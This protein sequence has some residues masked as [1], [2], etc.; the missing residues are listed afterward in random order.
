M[1]WLRLSAV[2]FRQV[3]KGLHKT[4][5]SFINIDCNTMQSI[6]FSLHQWAQLICGASLWNRR[7]DST[8]CQQVVFWLYLYMKAR[9]LTISVILQQWCH[10][11]WRKFCFRSMRF[12]LNSV[13][14][15]CEFPFDVNFCVCRASYIQTESRLTVLLLSSTKGNWLRVVANLVPVFETIISG[16]KIIIVHSLSNFGSRHCFPE[17]DYN[18]RQKYN[19]LFDFFLNHIIYSINLLNFMLKLNVTILKLEVFEL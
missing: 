16:D 2:T 9:L 14:S 12:W 11:L 17:C 7:H 19:R 6:W 4:A 15:L 18:I 8:G 1:A 10:Y 3:S 5:V 13:N